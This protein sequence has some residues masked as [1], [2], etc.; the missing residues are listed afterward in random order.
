LTIREDSNDP[1][2]PQ[3]FEAQMREEKLLLPGELLDSFWMDNTIPIF[4]G[5]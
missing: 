5:E 4:F 2:S 1:T 3:N